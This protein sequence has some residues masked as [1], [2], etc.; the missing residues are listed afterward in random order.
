MLGT[1]NH[2]AAASLVGVLIIWAKSV[3]TNGN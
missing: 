2:L 3:S 1:L